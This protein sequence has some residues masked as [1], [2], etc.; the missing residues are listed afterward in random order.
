MKW[1][2]MFLNMMVADLIVNEFNLAAIDVYLS[3]V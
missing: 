3:L 2:N 1:Q